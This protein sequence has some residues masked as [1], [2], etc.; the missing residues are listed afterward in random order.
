MGWML[1][2]HFLLLFVAVK[3]EFNTINNC[4]LYGWLINGRLSKNKIGIKK[5]QHQIAYHDDVDVNNP[6]TPI[7]W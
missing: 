5:Y 3:H 7:V 1:I 4:M 6:R 2:F